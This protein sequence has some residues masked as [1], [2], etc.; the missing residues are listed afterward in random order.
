MA[1][2]KAQQAASAAKQARLNE[3]MDNARKA[4]REKEQ[5][6]EREKEREKERKRVEKERLR[7]ERKAEEAAQ[8]RAQEI[9]AAQRA[10]ASSPQVGQKRK[11]PGDEKDL[12]QASPHDLRL[13]KAAD[14]NKGLTCFSCDLNHRPCSWEGEGED[15][16]ELEAIRACQGCRKSKAKCKFL[17]EL[18]LAESKKQRTTPADAGLSQ[19]QCIYDARERYLKERKRFNDALNRVEQAL[20]DQ[21][22][23]YTRLLA[24]RQA[25]W[26]REQSVSEVDPSEM[27]EAIDDLGPL[28]VDNVKAR[29]AE[30]EAAAAAAAK[31]AEKAKK[32]RAA[33]ARAA[34]KEAEEE[35]L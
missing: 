23:T 25:K 10:S 22:A 6:E 11:A 20:A 13:K 24:M 14:I 16:S 9:A 15:K 5:A 27:S 31:K 35:A 32:A 29:E 8:A 18:N 26:D 12:S 7:S 19:M 4:E 1:E 3:E 17:W 30:A 33:R 21:A 28:A 34:P 2:L